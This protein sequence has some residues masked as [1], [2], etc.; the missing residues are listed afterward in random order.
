MRGLDCLFLGGN[1]VSTA[2]PKLFRRNTQSHSSPPFYL[3]LGDS[4]FVREI[5]TELN[6]MVKKPKDFRQTD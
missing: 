4:N 1:L 2:K 6:D 3:I 5:E